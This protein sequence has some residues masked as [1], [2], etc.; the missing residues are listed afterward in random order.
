MSKN[1]VSIITPC[2]NGE[3]YI[4]KLLD[5]VLSQTYSSIEMFIIDD[6][7]TDKSSDIIKAYI[8][9]FKKRGFNLEYIYQPNQGQSVAI[10][11]ALK[12]IKGDYVVWPDA[13]DYYASPDAIKDMARELES[14][15]EN[16]SMVRVQY[17]VMNEAGKITGRLGVTNE[18]RYKTDLFEDC[19]LE[20]GITF[21]GAAGGYMAKVDK[22]DELIPGR[23][24]YTEK[25]AGQNYQICL[26][27]LYNHKILTI[28]KYYYNIVE[29]EDSHSR[30]L[31]TNNDR[32]K[33]NYRAILKTL[34]GIALPLDYKKYLIRE[35]KTAIDK[36][37]TVDHQGARTW[38][39][40]A[41]KGVVPHGGI[42]ILR[43]KGVL[44]TP[45]P[46]IVVHT[47]PKSELELVK[48]YD[49]KIFESGYA[50]GELSK[51]NIVGWM[52]FCAHV[53]E[54][55]MSREKFEAGHN[56]FRLEQLKRLLDDYEA[57][58]FD[59]KH[60]AYQYALSSIKVYIALHEDNNF[61]TNKIKD[62]LGKRYQEAIKSK[63]QLA[64]YKVI[65]KNNKKHNDK[66]NFADLQ[67]N[68]FSV[69]EFSVEG[70][71]VEDIRK[72]INLSMKSPS[73]CNRQGVRVYNI[74]NKK[75][76]RQILSIQGGFGGYDMPPCLLLV[77]FDVRSLVGINERNQG[78]IDGGLFS[79]SLLLS[80]EYY[81]LAA[82]SLNAM[83]I[84]ETDQKI[85]EIIGIE[86]PEYLI[87]FIAVGHFSNNTKVAV[88][89]R[90]NG[91]D[92]TTEII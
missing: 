36:L 55:A 77:S 22:I 82:C 38:F 9:K 56:I 40:R 42:V 68:R 20:Y 29:H 88:S 13:D 11:N 81:G 28:E 54:K 80:L 69:R 5:S 71:E 7:S 74:M 21:W 17:N 86:N 62:I 18:T 6:G 43:R 70:V 85:R 59:K 47:P 52:L 61:S 63:K 45:E 30:D 65:H 91:D 64:G 26:P 37:V 24:I 76:I 10:N 16:T 48:D 34:D 3:K 79:M 44:S 2:Y 57:K 27:L 14:S 73:I 51:E 78:F 41:L 84:P 90:Y 32:Q 53:L 46:Q 25:N 19:L 87:M 35:V 58:G 89:S 67:N 83:F 39:K 8:P 1:L 49:N 33:V 92:I 4:S 12:M 50:H 72:A 15:D 31:S 66:L 75:K 60:F 23:E